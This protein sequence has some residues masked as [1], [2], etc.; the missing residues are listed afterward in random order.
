MVK[1]H[2]K[3]AFAKNSKIKWDIENKNHSLAI[4]AVIYMIF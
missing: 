4:L 1:D 2:F 3:K